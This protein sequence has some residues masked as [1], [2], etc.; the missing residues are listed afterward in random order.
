M[1]AA[2]VTGS[3]K[4]ENVMISSTWCKNSIDIRSHLAMYLADGLKFDIG[5]ADPDKSMAGGV[6]TARNGMDRRNI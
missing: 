4:L 1:A 6:I 2:I 5:Y 3:S